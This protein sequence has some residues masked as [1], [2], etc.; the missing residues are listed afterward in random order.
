M[1]VDP[2]QVLAGFLTISMFV[3][4]GNMIKRDH[5]DSIDVVRLQE[6]STVQFDLIK[7]DEKINKATRDS[8]GPWKERSEVIKPCWNKPSSKDA[9]LSKGYITFSLTSGPEYH[10]SQMA[11]AVVIARY[12]GATLVLPDIRG[13]ELGNKRNFKDMYDVD[14]FMRSLDG[15]IKVVKALPDELASRQPAVVRVPNRV[16]EDFIVESIKPIFQTN[17]YLR[18]AI[19]FQSISFRLREKKNIEL[20]STACLA[21]FSSLELKPEINEVGERMVE[22][23]KTL[24][25][26]TD[27]Q[28][29]AVDLRVEMLEKKSC[30]VSGGARRKS[31]YNAQEVADFLR[32]VGFSQDTTVYL[33]QTWWHES[34]NPLKEAFPKTYTKDD[35]IPAEKKGEFLKS[36]SAELEKA[37]DFHVCSESDM[38]IPA[39]SGLFY[40]NVAGRRIASGRTQ[41]LV[42]SQVFG[43][44]ALASDFLSTYISKKNHVAYSCYC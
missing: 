6:A 23:L 41:I 42:P 34:L 31:C 27:G 12:L 40:G 4:L 38:F 29:V 30:K 17:N 15:V 16:S 21:M 7:V 18:L 39:I 22:R 33:T 9:E 11:D 2:R 44:S 5:F 24:S 43:S 10:I 32:K 28:F 13:Y 37:L 26:K 35:I 3:M 20:D 25:R 19:V 8:T 14:K 1:A 36:G